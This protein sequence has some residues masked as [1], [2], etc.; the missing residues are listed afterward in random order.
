MTLWKSRLPSR[1][2]SSCDTEQLEKASQQ[3]AEGEWIIA[4]WRE[5]IE[6]MQADGHDV[7]VARDL[8]DAFQRKL[9]TDARNAT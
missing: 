2:V 7:T 5:L 8:I 6:R 4:G 3:V 1:R 9:E